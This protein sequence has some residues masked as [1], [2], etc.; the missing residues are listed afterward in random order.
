[1]TRQ[2]VEQGKDVECVLLGAL[3][4]EV[5]VHVCDLGT[6]TEEDTMMPLMR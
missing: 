3:R 6:G 4:N 1:M 2:G 5:P